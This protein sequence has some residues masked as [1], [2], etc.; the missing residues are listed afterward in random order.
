[1]IEDATELLAV[2][3]A[4]QMSAELI[5]EL[6]AKKGHSPLVAI[7]TKAQEQA[8]IALQGLTAVD[9][10]KPAEIRRL[11]NE[12]ARFADLVRWLR[13]LVH[14]GIAASFLIEEHE[15]GRGYMGLMGIDP[16]LRRSL[17][18]DFDVPQERMKDA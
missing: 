3:R 2:E 1:M 11:Q 15:Q 8:V 12:F 17:E 10:E 4:S 14:D 7:L 5:A 9:P 6:T 16:D 18:R 13:E